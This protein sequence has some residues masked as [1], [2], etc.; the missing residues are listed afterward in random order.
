MKILYAAS[1]R[2]GAAE[3]LNRFLQAAM[4]FGHTIKISTFQ[5]TKCIQNIDW[6]LSS[7]GN[8]LGSTKSYIAN[9]AFDIYA[10]QIKSF[11]PDLIISDLED[12]TST[13]A[14]DL[15]IPIFQ[16]NSQVLFEGLT[17]S[18]TRKIGVI[19]QYPSLREDTLKNGRI[20]Q[21]LTNATQ[22]LAYSHL[23]DIDS[24]PNLSFGFEYVRP[25]HI[26]GKASS[27]CQHNLIA[28][29]P[30]GNNRKLIGRLAKEKD[31]ILFTDFLGEQFR[32]VILKSKSNL[33]EYACN[34]FNAN[35]VFNYGIEEHLS[36]AFYNG[37][38]SWIIPQ[39]DDVA[40]FNGLLAQYFKHGDM[41]FELEKPIERREI[42]KPNYN[43]QI[44]F[45][46]EKLGSV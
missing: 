29:T 42:K 9:D 18:A 22:K 40:F 46:H 39:L 12:K 5:Q 2:L 19:K 1:N 33:K 25:Y 36:D 24:A 37:Q 41:M 32:D 26:L 43:S 21:M 23:C 45:L 28:I 4:P 13:I 11:A 44:K 14:Y 15:S 17:H 27:M 38:F 31:V 7:L 30:I 8:I 35:I 3:Q 10:S 20:T 34:L 16:V 6:N